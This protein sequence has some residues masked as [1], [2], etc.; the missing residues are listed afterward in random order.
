LWAEQANLNNSTLFKDNIAM[1]RAK[2]SETPH[3][4]T[5]NLHHTQWT[6]VNAS[7]CHSW[8]TV[9]GITTQKNTIFTFQIPVIELVCLIPICHMYKQITKDVPVLIFMLRNKRAVLILGGKY[10]VRYD[11]VYFK[12]IKFLNIVYTNSI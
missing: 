4:N 2:F 5:F 6:L 9:L 10:V 1:E 8:K 7:L 3:V 12:I 11:L